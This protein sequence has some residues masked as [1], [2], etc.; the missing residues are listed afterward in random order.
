MDYRYQSGVEPTKILREM[1]VL[2]TQGRW[3]IV[4]YVVGFTAISAAAD[5]ADAN[6]SD[7]GSRMLL[8]N[9]ATIAAEYFLFLFL[10]RSTGLLASPLKRG[11]GTYFL[12]LLLKQLAIMLGILLFV[13]PGLILAIRWLPSYSY[14]VGQGLNAIPAL[15]RSWA[16]TKPHF[17]GLAT[18]AVFPVIGYALGIGVYLAPEF[19]PELYADGMFAGISLLANGLLCMA[20]ATWILLGVA[21]YSIMENGMQD[22]SDAFA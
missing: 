15:H 16:V 8:L 19:Y 17:L 1:S 3:A 20:S 10:M 12:Q 7:S 11:F 9:V 18:V 22:V 14:V 13:V 2:A 4:A 5:Y 6:S 21:F